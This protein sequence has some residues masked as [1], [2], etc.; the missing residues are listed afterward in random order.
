MK[1]NAELLF[2]CVRASRVPVLRESIAT[3]DIARPILETR[4][5]PL[6]DRG[7]RRDGPIREASTVARD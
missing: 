7:T 1:A 4:P 2:N 5:S 3:L 6:R